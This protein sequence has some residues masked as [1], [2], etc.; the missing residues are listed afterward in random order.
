MPRILG[1]EPP[2]F[3]VLAGA[4]GLGAVYFML[5]KP[6]A[7]GAT[8]DQAA[9]QPA[10]P[11]GA[12]GTGGL[13]PLFTPAPSSSAASS[14]TLP[15][16]KHREQLAGSGPIGPMAAGGPGS[17]LPASATLPSAPPAAATYPAASPP[18]A[19]STLPPVITGT[20]PGLASYEQS[21]LAHDQ[22]LVAARIMQLWARRR[23]AA[24][25]PPARRPPAAPWAGWL[26][27]QMAA[28]VSRPAAR[29]PAAGRT[30]FRGRAV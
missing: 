10:A 21:V 16:A 20:Y 24:R 5:H 17:S 7:G 28:R 11:G 25:R 29:R 2:A 6:A 4:A 13:A 23:P 3:A 9:G 18:R 15:P 27:R 22:P 12:A 30:P 8:G 19:P 26:A 14:A 1:L